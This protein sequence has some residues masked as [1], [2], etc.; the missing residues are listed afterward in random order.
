MNQQIKFDHL[1]AFLKKSA[2]QYGDT[3][4]AAFLHAITVLKV[5]QDLNSGSIDMNDHN[6][7]HAWAAVIMMAAEGVGATREEVKSQL[8]G[9]AAALKGDFEDFVT[10]AAQS[11][12]DSLL[13]SP[14]VTEYLSRLAG[15]S[16]H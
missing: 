2:Q 12:E 9:C 16:K 1:E 15:S 5:G 3:K 7:I 11:A 13:P 14:E 8:L 4:K 6:N 10:G